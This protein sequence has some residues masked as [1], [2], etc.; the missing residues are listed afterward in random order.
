MSP[1]APARSRNCRRL[2][3]SDRL[4]YAPV[5]VS[6]EDDISQKTLAVHGGEPRTYPVRRVGGADHA[7]RN[8]FV[9]RYGG[10]HRVLRRP[11]RT[12]RVR[13]LR[14]P[15]RPPGG[16]EGGS[17]RAHRGCR[18]VCKRHGCGD[19]HD[20]G[21]REVRL[22]RDSFCGL[23]SPDEAVRDDVSRSLRR[24]EHA[25]PAGGRRGAESRDSARDSLGDCRGA[26]Q[27]LPNDSRPRTGRRDLPREED[28]DARR[29]HVRNAD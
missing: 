5:L 24:I 21:A 29:Q 7:D 12:R 11:K 23:L 20:S 8:V 25:H 9:R 19:V 18:R 26:H 13:P 22:A 28:Q 6:D 15:V 14:Q 10:A 17:A 4:S 27:S 3:R 2:R 16:R 1:R